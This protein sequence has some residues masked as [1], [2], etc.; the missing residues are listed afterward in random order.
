MGANRY[1]KKY[2][3]PG[4]FELDKYLTDPDVTTIYYFGGKGASKTIG[5]CQA[6][7]KEAQSYNRSSIAFRKES[8]RIKKT[9]KKSMNLALSSIFVK[10]AFD[11][12]D[13]MYKHKEKLN[14]TEKI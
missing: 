8:T 2:F 12:Q 13:F 9:L 7:G 11:C 14:S 10:H 4:F 3:N 6:L 1:D 5:I